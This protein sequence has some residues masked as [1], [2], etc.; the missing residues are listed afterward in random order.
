MVKQ[1]MQPSVKEGG[2]RL[3]CR[4]SVWAVSQG[5]INSPFE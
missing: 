5:E 2:K 4:L 1:I 3:R